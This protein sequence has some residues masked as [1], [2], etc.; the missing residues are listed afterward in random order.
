M[1]VPIDFVDERNAR[2][3]MAV[4]AGH[5]S[6]PD[7]GS[8]RHAGSRRLF[9]QSVRKI[10][11]FKCFFVAES[12]GRAIGPAI[13]NIVAAR[14]WIENR[15]RP[16]LAIEFKLIPF[17]MID[18]FQKLV[19]HV[20][21]NVE[22]GE[23]VLIVLGMNESQH[24]GMRDA[25]HAH[26]RPATNAA[27][28]H[29]VGC[30]IENIHKRHRPAR[31]P[32]SRTYHGAT[33]TKLL[34][35]EPGAAAG[36]MNDRRIRCRLHDAGDRVRYIQHEASSELTIWLASVDQARS[37]GNKLPRQHNVGHRVKEFVALLG[38]GFGD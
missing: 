24:V 8:I 33:G 34:K 11:G 20:H 21:G 31:H 2:L 4:R 6:V 27:L 29:S 38:I 10:G 25:H 18:R 16:R 12:H 36:L 1:I 35:S 22:V 7:V 5:N 14:D 17:I 28:L 26:I 19:R 13:D 32:V 9:N 37:V 3:G 30:R 23:R 15:F